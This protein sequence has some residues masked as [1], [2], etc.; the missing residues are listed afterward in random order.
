MANTQNLKSLADRPEAER[1]EI[2]AMGGRASG[3]SRR[4]GKQLSERI[5]SL[6][7]LDCQYYEKRNIWRD[8]MGDL[9][10][11][12]PEHQHWWGVPEDYKPKQILDVIALKIVENAMNGDSKSIA[13][14]IDAVS[15]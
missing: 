10:T 9:A 7:Y 8:M 1:K 13:K 12:E 5:E 15:K 11:D 6:V 14:V 4:K 2:A 3:E